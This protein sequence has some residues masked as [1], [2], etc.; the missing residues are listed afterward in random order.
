MRTIGEWWPVAIE[1]PKNPHRPSSAA[2]ASRNQQIADYVGARV[3]ALGWKR[4]AQKRAMLEAVERFAV[5]KTTVE[6]AVR[7]A[8]DSEPRDQLPGARF[9]AT[10]SAIKNLFPQERRA[11]RIR[12]PKKAR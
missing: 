5:S 10:R 8:I 7:S 2:T 12:L 4:G 11:L 3:L 9:S 1:P 6:N